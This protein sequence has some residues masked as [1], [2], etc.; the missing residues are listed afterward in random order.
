MRDSPVV[1]LMVIIAFIPNDGHCGS[2]HITLYTDSHLW[3]YVEG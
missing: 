3:A 1:V 2:H